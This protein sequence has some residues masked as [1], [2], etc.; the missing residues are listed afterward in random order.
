MWVDSCVVVGARARVCVC[1]SWQWYLMKKND[2]EKVYVLYTAQHIC[3][4]E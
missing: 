2:G 4:S 3:S 1:A